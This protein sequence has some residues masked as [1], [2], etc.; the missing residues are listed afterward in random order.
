MISFG[1]NAEIVARPGSWGDVK[2]VLP[3]RSRKERETAALGAMAYALF[4]VVARESL[5]GLTKIK[6]PKGRPRKAG[7]PLSSKERQRRFRATRRNRLNRVAK[8]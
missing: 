4:D 6:L 8:K 3:I 5:K 7:R 2:I 1:K